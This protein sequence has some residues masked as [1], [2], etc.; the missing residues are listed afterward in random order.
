M[1]A[2]GNAQLDTAEKKFGTAS[3]LLDGTGDYVE[4]PDSADWNFGSGDLTIEAQLKPNAGAMAI[5][6]QYVDGNNFWTL[7]YDGTNLRFLCNSAGSTILDFSRAFTYTGN[8]DHVALTREGTTFRLWGNG[9]QLGSDYVDADALPD[10]AAP[11]F[12]GRN[13]TGVLNPDYSGW[14]DEFR[15]LKGTARWSANF[16]PPVVE[17]A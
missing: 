14:I 1:T 10:F 16:T 6:S 3:L 5:C 9:T 8:F 17:Y 13:N 7:L 2:N 15:I 4:A 12:I 11:L